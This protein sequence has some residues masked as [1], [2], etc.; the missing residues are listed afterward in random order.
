MQRYPYVQNYLV[1]ASLDR[2]LHSRHE[3]QECALGPLLLISI[4]N[5]SISDEKPIRI[6]KRYLFV[7]FSY[8]T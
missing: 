7:R 4:L 6:I 3:N 8:L 2:A 1:T 5:W